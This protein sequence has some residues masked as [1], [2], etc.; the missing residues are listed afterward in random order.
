MNLLDTLPVPDSSADELGPTYGT[1]G[2]TPKN[3]SVVNTYIIMSII[4]SVERNSTNIV[5]ALL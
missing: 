2:T 5:Y 3:L 4:C 1:Q